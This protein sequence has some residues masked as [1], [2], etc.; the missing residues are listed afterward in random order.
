MEEEQGLDA[1]YWICLCLRPVA[2]ILAS[3]TCRCYGGTATAPRSTSRLSPP[4]GRI[5]AAARRCSQSDT[6]RAPSTLDSFVHITPSLASTSP[7]YSCGGNA[8]LAFVNPGTPEGAE[9]FS[10]FVRWNTSSLNDASRW[11]ST[12]DTRNCQRDVKGRV[13]WG[14]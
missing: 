13:L 3:V 6:N 7:V 2:L 11:M 1:N 10:D 4:W 8:S 9:F 14:I 12:R 5:G